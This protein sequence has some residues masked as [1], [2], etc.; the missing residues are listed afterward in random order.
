MA[1]YV[2][3]PTRTFEAGGAI[4]ENLRVT[5]STGKLAVAG[6]A[7]KDLGTMSRP[8][9]ASG[10][11]VAVNLRNA[12]GTVKMVAAGAI[13]V[14]AAVHTAADGKV[15]DTAA[16]TSYLVG[17]AL[18]EATADGDVIEV[19]RNSHGDTAN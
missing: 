2:N 15:N 9:F 17:T 3:G 1:S 10:D 13:A 14:G 7:D 6:V 11:Q 12:P 5:L 4:A 19:L 8:S 16:S 18:S